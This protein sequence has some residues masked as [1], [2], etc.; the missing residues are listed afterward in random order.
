LSK[1]K[2]LREKNNKKQC[3]MAA[4]LKMSK[5]NYSKKESGYL[6]FSLHEAKIISDYFGKSIE[7]IFFENEVSKTETGFHTPPRQQ[8]SAVGE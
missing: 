3:D 6:R 7:N 8:H 1:I 2:E 4:L 5:C